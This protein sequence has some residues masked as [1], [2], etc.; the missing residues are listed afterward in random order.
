M[1]F[2]RKPRLE[3]HVLQHIL[4]EEKAAVEGSKGDCSNVD[5]IS[6]MGMNNIL[7]S[8]D[9]IETNVNLKPELKISEFNLNSVRLDVKGYGQG[10]NF[11]KNKHSKDSL[12]NLVHSGLISDM[13]KGEK[14]E[15]SARD[16]EFKKLI[17][18]NKEFNV[19]SDNQI[20]LR[21][22]NVSASSSNLARTNSRISLIDFTA[23]DILQHLMSRD[24]VKS[25]DFC[26]IIF[27]DPAMYYL[28]RS[29]HD[30]MDVRCCNLCGKLLNDKYDFIAHFLSQ[31]K[32]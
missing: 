15:L 31:H 22:T 29:M 23:E 25:C 11:D 6:V 16:N 9:L 8:E 27:H 13:I 7:R 21:Q 30:K 14:N 3:A 18:M 1:G 4:K 5:R 10:T 20:S 19:G 24:D 32:K 12:N 2:C 26:C 28:H 17:D